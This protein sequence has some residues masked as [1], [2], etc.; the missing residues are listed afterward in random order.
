MHLRDLKHLADVVHLALHGPSCVDLTLGVGRA[1][2]FAPFKIHEPGFAIL[3]MAKDVP[4]RDV[5][6]DDT[7]SM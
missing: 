3:R 5:V 6:M 4:P 1:D 7:R 2:I